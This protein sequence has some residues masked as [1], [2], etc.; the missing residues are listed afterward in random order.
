MTIEA[1]LAA[2]WVNTSIVIDGHDKADVPIVPVE[3][4]AFIPVNGIQAHYLQDRNTPLIT[5]SREYVLRRANPA[6]KVFLVLYSLVSA[7]CP[8][9]DNQ[10]YILGT[11]PFEKYEKTDELTIGMLLKT[12]RF[13]I[14][15]LLP[16]QGSTSKSYWFRLPFS[17]PS[18]QECD[19]DDC[20]ATIDEIDYRGKLMM[21][22]WDQRKNRSF[23]EKDGW[24][25]LKYLHGEEDDP[26][27]PYFD[28]SSDEGRA[29]ECTSYWALAFSCAH[30]KPALWSRWAHWERTLLRFRIERYFFKE[31]HFALFLQANNLL[32]K[33]GD[34]DGQDDGKAILIQDPGDRERTLYSSRYDAGTSVPDIWISV[35]VKQVGRRIAEDPEYDV[36]KGRVIITHRDFLCWAWT[37]YELAANELIKR[38]NRG[39]HHERG[40]DSNVGAMLS[41]V[42]SPLEDAIKLEG[43]IEAAIRLKRRME[44]Q[45]EDG[46]AMTLYDSGAPASLLELARQYFPPCMAR[47]IWKALLH[48]QHPKNE[49]RLSLVKF[50]LEAGYDVTEVERVMYL[51]YEADSKWHGGVWNEATFKREYGGQVKQLHTSVIEE[52]R[53]SAYGCATLTGDDKREKASGCPFAMTVGLEARAFL[54]WAGV[55][56]IEDVMKKPHPQERCCKYF[57]E[58]HP[59]RPPVTVRHP[60]QF[61][62]G[63]I[64]QPQGNKREKIEV[65]VV[66]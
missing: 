15:P 12:R 29:R 54:E 6:E 9:D 33:D 63:A 23:L 24:D 60:N 18:A 62:R 45:G 3:W 55:K 50:L 38:V 30:K 19:D 7:R 37:R 64:G 61:F 1:Q 58:R 52:K 51:L 36:D 2:W 16:W 48:T 25:M 22:F 53:I 31:R 49:S 56:D 28:L 27:R 13:D 44:E 40:R 4:V 66:E 11:Y 8:E 17:V 39:R 57:Q 42:L 43:E 21:L 34:E 32:S 5:A 59:D 46:N 35:P 47:H 41:V 10:V 26:T 20:T 65:A 14:T